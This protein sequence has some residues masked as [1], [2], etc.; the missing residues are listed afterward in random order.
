M[1]RIVLTIACLCL[2]PIFT[3]A[4][5]SQPFP[6]QKC[7]LTQTVGLT[8]VSITYFR[9][10]VKEREIWGKLVPIYESADLKKGQIP[11]RAGANENTEISF[12]TDVM[13]EG[14]K[15]EAG[16]YGFHIIP[17]K[18][19]W[20]V[21][22]STNHSSWGSYSY[23]KAEDALRVQVTPV[24]THHHELLTFDLLD[25]TKESA[26]IALSWEKKQI[27]IQLTVKT[28]DIVMASMKDALR[29]QAGFNWAG[30][31]TAARYALN[32]D[33]N[34]EQGLTW[35]DN[36]IAR[37]ANFTTMNTKAGLLTKLDREEE[38]AKVREKA[39]AVATN[40]ELNTYG[41]QL[42]NQGKKDEAIKVFKLNVEK[43]PSDPNVWDSLGEGYTTRSQDG[44]KKLAVKAFE[45]SL[46]L[47]P[48]ANVRANSMKHLKN[49]G[50]KKY[51]G[52]VETAKANK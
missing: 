41:Y 44:D 36:A 12:S 30:W 3:T 7:V 37:G 20:T 33:V 2:L 48:P 22:L 15:L 34:L 25:Q 5:L 31:N 46:S 29:S 13:L 52:D 8:E 18:G 49:M 21:A 16:T 51:M 43:N 24:T 27:P 50:V 26:T 28:H 4:Q 17:T 19:K 38:A 47:D 10:K 45:K 9:P 39:I 35:A 32:N 14:K 6:S 11:W 42:I 23:N 40:A 1:N